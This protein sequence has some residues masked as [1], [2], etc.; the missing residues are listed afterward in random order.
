[1]KRFIIL[2][3]LLTLSYGV[4][5]QF[6]IGAGPSLGIG[7][8][9]MKHHDFEQFTESYNSIIQSSDTYIEDL[10]SPRFSSA[11]SL[12]AQAFLGPMFLDWGYTKSNASTSTDFKYN[13]TRTFAFTRREGNYY[14]GAG[15]ASPEDGYYFSLGIGLNLMHTSIES[16]Y[17]YSNGVKSFGEDRV[18]NGIYSTTSLKFSVGGRFGIILGEVLGIGAKIDYMF[19]KGSGGEL[20][21]HDFSDGKVYSGGYSWDRIPMDYDPTQANL[22]ASEVGVSSLRSDL[23]FTLALTFFIGPNTF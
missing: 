4:F 20:A 2:S 10:K 15:A 21:Y 3:C 11:F 5:G 8:S 17:T 6:Y 19:K 23:R 16:S 22:P 1:M 7:F 12:G 14:F 13:Q 18:L 9:K